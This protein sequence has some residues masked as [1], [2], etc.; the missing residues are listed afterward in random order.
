MRCK[1]TATQVI[2]RLGASSPSAVR[3]RGRSRSARRRAPTHPRSRRTAARAGSWFRR[4][5][6]LA[7]AEAT[8]QTRRSRRRRGCGRRRPRSR[9]APSLREAVRARSRPVASAGRRSVP[10][11]RP[12]PRSTR[13]R[14]GARSRW[15]RNARADRA[16]P[17]RSRL[18]RRRA[19][20]RS[21]GQSTRS[22]RRPQQ[23]PGSASS[24]RTPPHCRGS[25]PGSRWQG[26]PVRTVSEIASGPP[27]GWRTRI[28]CGKT[29]SRS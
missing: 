29:M 17:A 11:P 24:C 7:T 23:G 25:P 1:A 9:R 16:G 3:P 27:P 4:P 10:A 12:R 14:Q 13:S 26:G 6:A 8:R 5:P 19:G 18:R 22:S 20:H 15:R 21:P 2:R 28:R